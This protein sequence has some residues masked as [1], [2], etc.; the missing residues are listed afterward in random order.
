MKNGRF[1]NCAR[2]TFHFV[3]SP[4]EIQAKSREAFQNIC[5]KIL[6]CVLV[7][8][9]D[10]RGVWGF[11]IKRMR[12]LLFILWGFIF[13]LSAFAQK[14]SFAGFYKGTIEGA[15]G[16]P[17]G[18][19]PD[20]YAEV[21]RGP[22]GY[23]IKILPAILSRAE[24]YYTMDN[25][26]AE[27]DTIA[28][29]GKSEYL[30]LEGRITPKDIEAKGSYNGKP[31]SLS[32]KRYEYVSPTMGAIPPAGSIVLFDGKDTSKWE[33]EDGKP[34]C[35]KVA[36]GAMTINVDLKNEKGKKIYTNLFTKDSFG[37]FKLHLEFLIPTDAYDKLGQARNNSGIIV[38]P[39]EMQILD[40]FGTEGAWNECGSVYRQ[41]PAQVNA[42]LEPGAW[43]TYDIIFKPAEFND[44]KLVKLPTFTAWINGKRVQN[45]T[46]IY[47][48]TSLF[49]NKAATFTHPQTPLKIQIQ[50]HTN[51]LSFRNIWIKPL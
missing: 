48:G 39:Y 16:Y 21:Y 3:V 26:K 41:T 51:P 15:K 1:L 33:H 8:R 6:I 5:F 22:Q 35:W 31:V 50:D 10:I 28:F 37:A 34:C 42:N 23:R 30:D 7:N 47:Y 38:G 17:V 18:S 14:D 44:G 43:Q 45:E 2:I 27:G 20:L 4:R 32:L 19:C 12:K 46:P 49:P 36:D 11:I 25:L 24:S 9:I 40:S 13:A 29:K